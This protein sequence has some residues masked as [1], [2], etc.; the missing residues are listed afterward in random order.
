MSSNEIVK[1][2]YSKED[3]RIELEL[4]P[5]KFKKRME[6]ITK[7]FKIDMKIFHNYKGQDKNNQYTFNGVAKELIKVL[8]KSIDYYP[9]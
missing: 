7:L 9:V 4:T 2:L 3:I 8:L 5:H 1:K 6:T